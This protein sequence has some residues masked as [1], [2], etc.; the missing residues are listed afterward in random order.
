MTRTSFIYP[1]ANYFYLPTFL[2]VTLQV[3][4]ANLFKSASKPIPF[5]V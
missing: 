5:P 3:F 2:K 1:N 4:W